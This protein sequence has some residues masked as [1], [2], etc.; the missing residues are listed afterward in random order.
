[1]HGLINRSIEAFLRGT[2]GDALWQRVCAA[3]GCP[4]EGF[5]AMLDYPDRLTEALI[6]AAVEA[7]GKPREVLLEDVGARLASY[8]NLRRLLRFGGVDF[9]DFLLSCSELP[10]RARLAV[11]DLDLPGIEVGGIA[12][13]R[14]T[15]RL[16]SAW[17]GYGA[18]MAGLLRAMAD[19]YGALVLID[20]AQDPGAE[21]VTVELLDARHTDGR[22]FRLAQTGT[23]GFAAGG[24]P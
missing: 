10:D 16:P 19:D 23:E 21:R 1:M 24:A 22:Q 18:L 11:P 14:I 5:E 8:E 12:G 9:L 20:H 6:A 15:L 3:S 13:N 17:P 4:A 2:Y 7:L